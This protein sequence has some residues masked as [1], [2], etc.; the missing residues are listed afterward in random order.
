M[1]DSAGVQ[2]ILDGNCKRWPW[3]RQLFVDRAYPSGFPP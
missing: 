3:M 1:S 2:V